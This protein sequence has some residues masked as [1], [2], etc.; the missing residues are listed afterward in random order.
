[1]SIR[2]RKLTLLSLLGI[3]AA[4]VAALAGM[5]SDGAEVPAAPVP[6]TI[7][8]NRDVRPIF[9]E[10]CY[11]CHGFDKN[12]RKADLRLDTKDGIMAAGENGP[13]VTPGRPDKS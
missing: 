12:K 5:R 9:S 1:M 2:T 13:I 8:F 6:E 4:V 7:Q 3:T 10:N 11:A